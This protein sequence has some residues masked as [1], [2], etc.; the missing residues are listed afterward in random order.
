MGDSKS[1]GLTQ[2]RV[3]SKLGKKLSQ[4]RKSLCKVLLEGIFF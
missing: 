2:A 4:L 3:I 1:A